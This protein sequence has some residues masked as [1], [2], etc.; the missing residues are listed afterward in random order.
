VFSKPV[1]K[2]IE[3]DESSAPEAHQPP[4]ENLS[5]SAISRDL[6]V[7]H[8]SPIPGQVGDACARFG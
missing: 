2:S 1:E 8:V 6:L 7:Q 4:A 3:G 5:L